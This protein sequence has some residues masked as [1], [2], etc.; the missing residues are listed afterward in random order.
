MKL[1]KFALVFN[2]FFNTTS[3]FF[4]P[5]IFGGWHPV[6]I[7]DNIDKTKPYLINYG[8]LPL[9]LLFNDTKPQTRI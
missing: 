6:A 8:K 7:Y 9:V 4:L 2:L 5:Q 3:G 1:C